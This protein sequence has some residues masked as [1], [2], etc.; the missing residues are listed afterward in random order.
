MV[1][2]SAWGRCHGAGNGCSIAW[3]GGEG[4]PAM[5]SLL[6]LGQKAAPLCPI[7]RLNK[8]QSQSQGTANA[9]CLVGLPA[10]H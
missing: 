4:Q 2:A 9:P 1:E 10:S 3:P 5:P 6:Q 8:A 7:S